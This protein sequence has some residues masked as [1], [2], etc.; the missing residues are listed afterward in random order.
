MPDVRKSRDQV[1]TRPPRLEEPSRQGSGVVAS[2]GLDLIACDG[3]GR[4][5]ATWDGREM[6]AAIKGPC[7]SCGGRFQ[8][9]A[10]SPPRTA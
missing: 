8:L 6:I 4:R 9:V 1:D 10:K 3:C 5:F 7:P 2:V